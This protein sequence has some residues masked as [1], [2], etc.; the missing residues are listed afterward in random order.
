MR[1]LL[2]SSLSG[3]FAHILPGSQARWGCSE[4]I[5][6]KTVVPVLPAPTTIMGS[7]VSIVKAPNLSGYA[8]LPQGSICYCQHSSSISE[9]LSLVAIS[10]RKSD[11]IDIHESSCSAGDGTTHELNDTQL[12]T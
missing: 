6:W 9:M 4:S 1:S 8:L 7:F 10:R 11:P 2:N 5:R 12:S 3:N